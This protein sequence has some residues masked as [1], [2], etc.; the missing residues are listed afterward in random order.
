MSSERP[1]FN[2]HEVSSCVLPM[3]T[4]TRKELA[5]RGEDGWLPSVRGCLSDSK[6]SAASCPE[7]RLIR[8]CV[9]SKHPA[10]AGDM[11]AKA[12]KVRTPEV[13]L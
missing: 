4:L 7:P 1:I 12:K 8:R 6:L 10:T 5:L 2:M 3:R 13:L 9:G 11:H